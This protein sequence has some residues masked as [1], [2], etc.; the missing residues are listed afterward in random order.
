MDNES[1]MSYVERGKKYEDEGNYVAAIEEYSR[2]IEKS[3]TQNDV[4]YAMR[5]GAYIGSRQYDKAIEDAT[6]AISLN[7]ND[8]RHFTNRGIAYVN[9]GKYEEAR[10]DW[11]TALRL[12]PNDSDAKANLD[13][14]KSSGKT[15]LNG[16]R[17]RHLIVIAVF[18]GV[19]AGIGLIGGLFSTLI[20]GIIWAVIGAIFGIGIIPWLAYM[21]EELGV[22]LEANRDHGFS[23]TTVLSFVFFMWFIMIWASIRS[24]FVGIYQLVTGNYD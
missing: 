24:P 19:F 12:N 15:P 8:S 16:K 1:T 3:S 2:A 22:Q 21:K 6:Q 7:S 4:I 14:L 23:L 5:S 10:S 13:R 11:E 9:L 17:K 18:A 20:F